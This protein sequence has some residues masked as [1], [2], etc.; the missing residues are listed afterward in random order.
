MF[1]EFYT[2]TSIFTDIKL[3]WP[4]NFK[5]TSLAQSYVKTSWKVYL[6]KILIFSDEA[7][8]HLSGCVI[9]ENFCFWGANRPKLV[10]ER[11]FIVNVSLD[12]AQF[13]GPNFLN[14]KV[15]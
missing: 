5:R 9:K 10:H 11:F 2:L 1:V 14:K 12:G 6:Q 3:S 13:H 8:F 7:H 4:K 15:L